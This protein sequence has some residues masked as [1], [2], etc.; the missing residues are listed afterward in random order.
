MKLTKS[1]G[2]KLL[3]LCKGD[4]IPA[5]KLNYPLVMELLAEGI[6]LDNRSGRSK[7]V[8]YIQLPE[9]LNA[10]LFNRFSI[11]DL[12]NYIES[13]DSIDLS[14]AV[15]V[16]YASD[17]K[18]KKVRTF[19]GFIVNSYQPISAKLDKIEIII[20][21]PLGTFQFIH[22]YEHFVPDPQ[23]IIVGIENSENFSQISKQQYLFNGIQTLFVSRYPQSQNRDLIK[24]LQKI[25][26]SYIHFGD[27][28]FAGIGIYLNEYKKHLGKRAAFLIPQG[29]ETL[30]AKCGSKR[31]Y[32]VQKATFKVDQIEELGLLKLVQLLH[33]YKKGLEQEALISLS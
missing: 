33:K 20:D 22:N 4:R 14:R 18:V 2:V 8:L 19:K 31:L 25:P 9:A 16:K 26:N 10:F 29:I 32:D 5:S 3:Q 7:S 17:S 24:W 12:K 1:L 11:S 28:D 15:L 21:P 30:L 6:I 23:V 13:L 27:F